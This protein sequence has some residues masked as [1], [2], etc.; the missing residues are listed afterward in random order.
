MLENFAA[1]TAPTTGSLGRATG[2]LWYDK[3]TSSETLNVYN[4]A[5]WDQIANTNRGAGATSGTL[6]WDNAT[7]TWTESLRVTVTA[8]GALGIIGPTPGNS[9]SFTHDDTDLNVVGVSTVD[10]NVTGVTI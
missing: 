2:Q 8:A 6:R 3:T 1:T 5:T 4:G 9:V 7:N 10:I